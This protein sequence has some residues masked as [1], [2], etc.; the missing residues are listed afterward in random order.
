MEV[1]RLTTKGMARPRAWGQAM[2]RTVTVRRKASSVRPRPA[3]TANVA[4]PASRA[5]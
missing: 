2:T 3:Q 1:D 5:T 4:N